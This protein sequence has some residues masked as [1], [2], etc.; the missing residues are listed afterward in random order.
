MPF[1]PSISPE[2][3]S[4]LTDGFTGAELTAVC[5]NAALRAIERDISTRT[6]N[7]L[8]ANF[9]NLFFAFRFLSMTCLT[10]FP[11]LKSN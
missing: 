2:T 10:A 4:R 7:I 9:F 5:Q 6:V 3:V 1:D 8:A 11:S